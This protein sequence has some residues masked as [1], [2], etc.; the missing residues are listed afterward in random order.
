[1]AISVV[2]M[3]LGD[4][5][6]V[7]GLRDIHSRL[8]EFF[9]GQRA[10]IE[11]LLAALKDFLLRVER[12]LGLLRVGFG[13]LD[14]FRQTGRGGGFVGRLRPVRRRLWCPAPRRSDRDSRAPPAVLPREPGCRASPETSAPE[15]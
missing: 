8:V 2:Q 9:S 14:F 6:L 7:A 13:F 10:L 3:L 4:R 15:R 5:V 11:E 12:L 1:M